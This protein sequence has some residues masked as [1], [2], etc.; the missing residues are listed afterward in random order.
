MNWKLLLF[1]WFGAGVG[2][3]I[4]FLGGYLAGRE[5]QLKETRMECAAQQVEWMKEKSRL[6]FQ[7]EEATRQSE[8]TFL[9]VRL[10]MLREHSVVMDPG[11]NPWR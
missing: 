8:E 6:L 11:V 2:C 3:G 9:Y 4:A 5:R 7:V 10:H 1:V